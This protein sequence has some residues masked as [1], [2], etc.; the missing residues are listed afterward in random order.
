M[1]FVV[2]ANESPAVVD[3]FK[4]MFP[5]HT[6][7]HV[8]DLNLQHEEDIVLFE[9]LPDLGVDA[10]ITRDRNQLRR[11]HE[12]AALKKSRLSWIGHK[13][14]PGRGGEAIRPVVAAYAL[15]LPHIFTAME[16]AGEPLMFTVRRLPQG[17]SQ[18][19]EAR[20]ISDST[21]YALPR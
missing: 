7:A 17:A 16:E 9:A 19:L 2:D 14:P 13:E 20:R 8:A 4:L 11:S 18:R 1:K 12:I 10:F 5:G 21:K 3:F 15:A 6:F